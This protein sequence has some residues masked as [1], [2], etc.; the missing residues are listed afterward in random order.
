MDGG[1]LAATFE[2]N[3][4]PILA[5]AGAGVVG[6]ALLKRKSGA[7]AAGPTSNVSSGQQT[8]GMTGAAAYD[9]S[10]SDLYGAI[11]PQLE[12]LGGQLADLR[13][14]WNSTPP[15]PVPAPT[16]PPSSYTPPVA[17][18]PAATPVP[19]VGTPIDPA[20]TTAGAGGYAGTWTQTRTN[21]VPDGGLIP[22]FGW[23]AP[24]GKPAVG[25]TLYNTAGKAIGTLTA[26]TFG[27]APQNSFFDGVSMDDAYN[28]TKNPIYK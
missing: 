20:M 5:A 26:Y 18:P 22:S 15:I 6:L 16:P 8:A 11:Q 24:T 4:V 12:S 17:A 1:T 7:A 28:A 25:S 27:G 10:A 2:A 9:S 13:N 14:Q 21:G 19:P 23:T 3:R